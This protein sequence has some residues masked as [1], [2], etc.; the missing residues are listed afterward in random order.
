M[1]DR[2][3]DLS[4][5]EGRY[6]FSD[7]HPSNSLSVFSEKSRTL[8]LLPKYT[9]SR[10]ERDSLYVNLEEAGPMDR[11]LFFLNDIYIYIHHYSSLLPLLGLFV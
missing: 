3:F 4:D 2:D 10:Q 5:P 1:T 7:P 6:S 8:S 9:L 11:G